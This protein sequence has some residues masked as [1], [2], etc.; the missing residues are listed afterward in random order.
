MT[1]DDIDR[2]LLIHLDSDHSCFAD[3]SIRQ[4]TARLACLIEEGLVAVRKA[5]PPDWGVPGTICRGGYERTK[6]GEWR[7]A[8]L[9]SL[10]SG[11]TIAVR[12]G[13]TVDDTAETNE[14]DIR[15]AIDDRDYTRRSR[16]G[17]EQ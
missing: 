12:S 13:S 6:A 9:E 2:L 8:E 15:R 16:D 7:L 17:T 3:I 11:R 4:V 5:P 14:P 1:D 10:R